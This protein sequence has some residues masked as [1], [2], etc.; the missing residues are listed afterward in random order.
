[1]AFTYQNA[2]LKKRVQ[3]IADAFVAVACIECDVGGEAEQLR[4]SLRQ[5]CEALGGVDFIVHA[6]AWSDRET[7]QGRYLDTDREVFLQ[8]LDISCFSFTA[9]IRACEA[10]LNDGASLLTL[11]YDGSQRVVPSYNVMGVA[12]AALES[13]V[14]YLAHDLGRRGI[15]VN[16]LSAAPMRTLSGAAVENARFIYQWQGQNCCLKRN[17]TL[18]EVGNA[19]LYLLSDLSAGVSGEVHYIDGGY[20]NIGMINPYY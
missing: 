8:T 6:V 12:K 14:R 10:H 18:E 16:A 3:P 2:L 4:Q 1:M 9:V 11:T 17:V 5:V 13:S 19:G 15:R 20:H 7:L